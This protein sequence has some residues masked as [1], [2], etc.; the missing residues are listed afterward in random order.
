MT[1]GDQSLEIK[2]SSKEQ[3]GGKKR[4]DINNS[5]QKNLLV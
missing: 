3:Y 4:D 5:K 2:Q 1:G